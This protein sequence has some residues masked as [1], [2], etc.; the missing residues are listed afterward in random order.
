MSRVLK[1]LNGSG[2]LG[3][4]VDLDEFLMDT[5]ATPLRDALDLLSLAAVQRNLY[6]GGS[7][8]T[9]IPAT[10]TGDVVLYDY[11]P[12]L[13]PNDNNQIGGYVDSAGGATL[14]RQV[15]V[16]AR[17]SNAAINITPKIWYGSSMTAITTA[18]SLTGAAA[19]SA[20]NAD[21]SGTNQIQ[22]VTFTLPTGAKYFK[23]G[24]TIAGTPAADYQ[25][26]GRAYYDCYVSS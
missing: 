5:H 25:I 16:F 4:W 12:W 6:V 3:I 26:W 15:R 23:V 9:G 13:V 11:V 2:A 14:T 10:A 17:V 20:T 24:F 7:E 21:Y 8:L 18:L 22:T 1:R 19:C